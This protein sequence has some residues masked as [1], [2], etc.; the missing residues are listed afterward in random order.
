MPQTPPLPREPRLIIVSGPSG[1]GKS[2]V[3]KRL[4]SDCSLPIQMSVSAT[5]RSPRPGEVNGVDYHFLSRDEFQRRRE[6]GEFLECFEV[7]GR[8]D[9]YGT[10]RESVTSG[11]KAGKWILLEIDVQGAMAT[12]QTYPQAITIFIHPGS[13]EE[14][15]RRLANRG[16]ETPES[17]RR[18]LE[19]A[20]VELEAAPRYRHTVVNHEPGQAA[21]EICQLLMT[22]GDAERCTTS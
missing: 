2:T 17:L 1:A 3:V 10:L 6:G 8:G 14:L 15:E 5:T 13:L 22:A 19:V 20:R 21:Q 11:L 7:F 4:L 9:W 18:R 12:L 16:S